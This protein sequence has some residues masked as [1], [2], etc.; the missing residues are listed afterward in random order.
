ML[1]S[2]VRRGM[3]GSVLAAGLV[4]LAVVVGEAWRKRRRRRKAWQKASSSDHQAVNEAF[5]FDQ[6]DSEFERLV[7]TCTNTIRRQ[8]EIDRRPGATTDRGATGLRSAQRAPTPMEADMSRP[9]TRR[10]MAEDLSRPK[11]QGGAGRRRTGMLV[12][13]GPGVYAAFNSSINGPATALQTADRDQR[14][15]VTACPGWPNPVPVPPA[16]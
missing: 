15:S 1:S 16:P 8:G 10:Q 9:R 4:V 11:A 6:P 3:A 12:A 5:L 2:T 14:P 7:L 13:A